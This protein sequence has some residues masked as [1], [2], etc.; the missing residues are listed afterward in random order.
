MLFQVVLKET[1]DASHTSTAA[2]VQMQI[3]QQL[4]TVNKRLNSMDGEVADIK[5][6]SASDKISSLS[7]TK[8][9]H[10]DQDSDSSSD[11]SLVPSLSHLKSAKTFSVKLT[12]V[13]VSLK[14]VVSLLKVKK[15]KSKR[16]D[17]VDVIVS[18]RVPWP[19]DTVLGG[20]SRQCMSYDQLTWCQWV[21]GFAR[22]ILEEKSQK[23]RENMLNYFSDLMEDANDFSWHGT[24]VAH[25]L[26]MCDMER[27]LSLGMILP[28]LPKSMFKTFGKNGEMVNKR[29][30]FCKLYQSGACA[31]AKDHDSNGKLHSHSCANCFDK[32]RQLNHPE[33]DCLLSKKQSKTSSQLLWAQKTFEQLCTWSKSSAIWY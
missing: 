4:Q 30:K 32:S 11:D 33:K 23:T 6:K 31:F 13:Y 27:G 19:H 15:I 10:I 16:G 22:N 17:N 1:Q 12:V 2:D 21:Q 28:V 24:K 3:L 9:A 20:S 5:Q 29:P 14:I 7:L 18:K 26:L 8:S 25:A